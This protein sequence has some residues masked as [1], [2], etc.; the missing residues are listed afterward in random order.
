[1]TAEIIGDRMSGKRSGGPSLLLGLPAVV[2]FAGFALLPMV[3][4]AVLTLFQ[5]DGLGTPTFIGLDNWQRFASDS[6][7]QQALWLSLKVM[8]VNWLIQTPVSLLLGVF[9][10]GHH[11]YRE[12]LAVVYFVPLLLSSAAISVMFRAMLDPNLGLLSSFA[13]IPGLGWVANWNLGNPELALYVIIGVI[14]WMFMPFHTLLYQAGARQIPQSMYD[15][16]SMDGAGRMQQF[17]H[18]TLP[19]LRYTIVTSTTLILIG[20][21]TYFETV[22]IMTGG[23]PGYATR[24]LP[25]HMYHQG[26]AAYDMGYASTIALTLVVF[27][28]ALSGLLI[29]F[30]GFG[31]MTSQQEGG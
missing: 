30:S 16:A 12:I 19:Q 2:L 13:A 3:L 18:I 20:S 1:M 28:L 7:L 21:L 5:W 6:V 22:F 25:L 26:F 8:V 17:F 15:A 9:L 27:G 23:G 10:A 4:V 14:S 24:I 29:R 11:R 31:R